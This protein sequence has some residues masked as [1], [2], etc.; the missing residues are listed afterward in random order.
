MM[1]TVLLHEWN[2]KNANAFYKSSA[3]KA[4]FLYLA[5]TSPHWPL[6]ALPEDIKKIREA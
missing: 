1:T 3:A 2:P 4:F 6:Q 5:Y